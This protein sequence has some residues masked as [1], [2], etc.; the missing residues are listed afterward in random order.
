MRNLSM[1]KQYSYLPFYSSSEERLRKIVQELMESMGF[2]Q[3][4]EDVLD[5]PIVGYELKA[6]LEFL[7]NFQEYTEEDLFMLTVDL[8]FSYGGTLLSPKP[9]FFLE[10]I[11]REIICSPEQVTEEIRRQR[12]D[13]TKR[14]EALYTRDMNV[15]GW[16]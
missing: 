16:Q 6:W 10:G 13:I 9:Y 5:Y 2:P 4:P 1:W 8:T 11:L 14:S 15:R 7:Q 12:E 3:Y